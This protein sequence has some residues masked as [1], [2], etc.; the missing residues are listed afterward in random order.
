MR[1]L[2]SV[3]LVFCMILS[4]AGCGTSTSEGVKEPVDVYVNNSVSEN[5]LSEENIMLND[6]GIK[7]TAKEISNSGMYGPELKML[8]ENDSEYNLTIK[9]K[10]MSIN[11]Y[12]YDPMFS[13]DIASGKKSNSSVLITNEFIE[14]CEIKE[15]NSVEFSVEAIVA[16]SLETYFVGENM[17]VEIKSNEYEQNYNDNGIVIYDDN[18]IKIVAKNISENTSAIGSEL[19]LYIENNRENNITIQTRNTSVNNFM[20]DSV[21]SQEIV[22]GKH[23]VSSVTFMKEDLEENE[24]EEIK[25]IELSFHIF[26]SSTSDIIV[27]TDI[28]TVSF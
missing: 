13:L 27:D 4:F 12:M 24:I 25:D 2:I 26:D 15:I 22:A 11:A 28:V 21:F 18:G 9:I 14:K 1:K 6:M 3:L 23:A 19:L 17:S 8:I 20:I 16:D 5:V 7:I 10:N